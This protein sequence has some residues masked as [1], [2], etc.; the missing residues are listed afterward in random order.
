MY[1]ITGYLYLQEILIH[2]IFY[3]SVVNE[4]DEFFSQQMDD[5]LARVGRSSCQVFLKEALCLSLVGCGY[6]FLR[7]VFF[8]ILIDE[9]DL[10]W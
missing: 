5:F 10:M 3:L 1:D 7:N 9:L 8:D 4:D 6:F 2:E